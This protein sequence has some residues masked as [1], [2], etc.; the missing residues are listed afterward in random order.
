MW[1]SNPEPINVYRYG[2][3][4]GV[5]MDSEEREFHCYY[6]LKLEATFYPKLALFLEMIRFKIVALSV[7]LGGTIVIN[8]ASSTESVAQIRTTCRV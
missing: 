5:E 6:I 2:R 4:P 8:D 7:V 3:G 1:S